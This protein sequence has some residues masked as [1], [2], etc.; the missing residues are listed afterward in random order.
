MKR[1]LSTLLTGIFYLYFIST[2]VFVPYFNW[3]F[4]KEN[5]FTKWL[6]FGE[7]I[8]TGKGLIWPFFIF[9]DKSK[10]DSITHL[11]KSIDLTNEGTKILNQVTAFTL[12]SDNQMKQYINFLKDALIEGDQVNIEKLNKDH[13]NFGNHF[14]DEYIKGIKSLISGYELKRD[15]NFVQGQL[16]L[17]SWGNWYSANFENIKSR[18]K[19]EVKIT[20]NT[21]T[22]PIEEPKLNS[23][24]L[25]RYSRVLK[26]AEEGVLN[27]ADLDELRSAIRDY[28]S[29]TGKYLT[30]EEYNSYIG[31]IKLANDYIY[32]LGV[33]LLYSWDQ[34]KI[35]TTDKF[36][37]LHKTMTTLKLRKEEKLKNDLKDLKAASLNQTYVEDESGQK[38]EFGREI[39]LQHMK[40][41]EISNSN[42]T[43]IQIIMKEFVK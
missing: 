26:K 10:D 8:A 22:V 11:N 3:T 23:S 18:K 42:I 31:F 2:I 32:E 9:V 38:Y 36:D 35:F 15:Q 39:I 1:I 19:V 4:A 37:D 21:K 28:I 5:G 41:N 6:L 7:V 30:E 34:K 17:D 14:R 12:M 29:R 13:P 16:L 43:S 25:D 24:E 40:Q 33:S 27:Q 20:Q